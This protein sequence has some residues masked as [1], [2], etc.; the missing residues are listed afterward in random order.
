ML[1]GRTALERVINSRHQNRASMGESATRCE[2]RT[3]DRSGT[4][5]VVVDDGLGKGLGARA[6][7]GTE[8][9]CCKLLQKARLYGG[10]STVGQVL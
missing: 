3:L 5:E 7:R 9:V 1:K 6:L 10:S 4:G 8:L 2:A